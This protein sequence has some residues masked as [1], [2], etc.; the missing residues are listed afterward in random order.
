MNVFYES[1]KDPQNLLK[2]GKLANT[3]A[4]YWFPC[5]RLCDEI[6]TYSVSDELEKNTYISN[7]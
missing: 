7:A 1:K 6:F 3:L 5:N 4:Y 2:V